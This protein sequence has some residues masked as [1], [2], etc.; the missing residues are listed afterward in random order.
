MSA[1]QLVG[2]DSM[3]LNNERL[4]RGESTENKAYIDMVKVQELELEKLKAFEKKYG[5]D[6]ESINN[7]G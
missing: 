2:M 4:I 1:Y 5:I 3:T 7:E 6:D